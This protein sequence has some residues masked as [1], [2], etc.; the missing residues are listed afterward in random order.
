[1]LSVVFNT[2]RT[3]PFRDTQNQMDTQTPLTDRE[4]SRRCSDRTDAHRDRQRHRRRQHKAAFR[5]AQGTDPDS[6]KSQRTD[7]K[8]NEAE[9]SNLDLLLVK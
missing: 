2:N 3:E 5:K 4:T 9:N 6:C 1:M 7:D 8:G